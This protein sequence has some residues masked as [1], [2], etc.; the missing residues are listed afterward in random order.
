[1][2]IDSAQFGSIDVAEDKLIEFPAGLPGFE[3]CKRFALVH[4]EGTDRVA[5][6][7]SAD[8]PE[9][10][11]SLA[12]PATFGVHYEFKLSDEEQTALGLSSPEQALVVVI[13]RKDEAAEGSPASAGLRA[14]F[15]APLVI[16]VD[17]RR[18]LQKVISKM[19]CDIVMR[20][21]D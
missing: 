2:K 3:H 18:G 16:N 1:M 5:L 17:A 14:N 11:F 7:H 6:L 8:D 12:D 9:V 20:A 4:E 15:M 21:K 10:V 19:E 13:V